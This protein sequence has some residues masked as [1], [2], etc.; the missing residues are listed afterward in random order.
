MTILPAVDTTA[1]A[2][3]APA[4]ATTP[5]LIKPGVGWVFNPATGAWD[6]D[7]VTPAALPSALVGTD[8]VQVV[9]G[10]GPNALPYFVPFSTFQAAVGGGAPSPT[11]TPSPTAPAYTFAF[12]Q[13]TNTQAEARLDFNVSSA[14]GLTRYTPTTLPV[15][16][17]SLSVGW[18]TSTTVAPVPG[19]RAYGPASWVNYQAGFW[20]GYVG[21]YP[22]AGAPG[23]YYPWV[24]TSDGAAYCFATHPFT[25]Q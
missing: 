9:R 15:A 14:D 5:G 21:S 7:S 18:S 11:P 19:S 10:T 24:I 3:T 17:W 13:E 25:F 23:T 4:T 8:L 6:V 1:R 16:G 20:Q 22:M 12:S 2:A